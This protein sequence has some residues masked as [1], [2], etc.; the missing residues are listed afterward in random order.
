MV[1]N[2]E[3]VRDLLIYVEQ[4]QPVKSDGRPESFKLMQY[5]SSCTEH[6]S[7][8]LGDINLA[9]RYLTDKGLIEAENL[10]G[11]TR[12]IVIVRITAAGYD[13]LG[14]IRDASRWNALK[15]KFGKIF[16]SSAPVL[17]EML[18]KHLISLD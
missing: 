11:H 12:R 7:Y 16:D 15:K 9:I 10:N 14:A 13:Y 5:C 2:Q 8:S 6:N 18:I 3:C 1:L 4:N 17:V